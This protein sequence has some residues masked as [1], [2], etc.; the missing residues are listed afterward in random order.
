M[1]GTDGK[2]A[3]ELLQVYRHL[4]DRL[5]QIE[6]DGHAGIAGNGGCLPAREEATIGG[7]DM[8]EADQ[9]CAVGEHVCKI[10]EEM[11]VVDFF[12]SQHDDLDAVL[13]L[14]R[15]GEPVGADMLERG[16][17][18]LVALLPVETAHDLL[19][20]PRGV[21]LDAEFLF[22]DVKHAGQSAAGGGLAFGM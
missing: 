15:M 9:A 20:G 7:G 3:V 12:G 13:L 16:H 2:V 11:L 4:S 17:D 19:H 21:G 18:E 22:P 8:A 14:K 5:G 6:H 1:T 10:T